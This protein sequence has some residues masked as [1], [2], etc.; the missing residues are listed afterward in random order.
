MY[1]REVSWTDYEEK[2]L[3]DS[4]TEKRVLA[5]RSLVTVKWT[6][7]KER[8]VLSSSYTLRNISAIHRAIVIAFVQIVQVVQQSFK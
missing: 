2:F 8:R 3:K 6:F 5:V 4:D 1:S 7:F